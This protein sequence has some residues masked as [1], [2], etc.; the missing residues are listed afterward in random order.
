MFQCLSLCMCLVCCASPKPSRSQTNYQ[1]HVLNRCQQKRQDLFSPFCQITVI[2]LN[3]SYGELIHIGRISMP[4]KRSVHFVRRRGDVR[5]DKYCSF[6]PDLGVN[7][8]CTAAHCPL[9]VGNGAFFKM[10]YLDCNDLG[11]SKDPGSVLKRT[12]Y[13]TVGGRPVT[14]QL[15][16]TLATWYLVWSS[17]KHETEVKD[18]KGNKK[19]FISSCQ[20][21]LY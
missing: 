4:L 5:R 13:S 10:I 20:G 15:S 7:L 21:H 1:L 19:W 12:F 9:W 17:M 2:V 8:P 3:D 6:P 16:F 14:D 11:A 18:K